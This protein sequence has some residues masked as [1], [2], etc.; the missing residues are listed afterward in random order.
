MFKCKYHIKRATIRN[1][2]GFIWKRQPGKV[3]ILSSEE[4]LREL[5]LLNLQKRDLINSSHAEERVDLFRVALEFKSKQSG[6]QFSRGRSWLSV[7]KDSFEYW[8]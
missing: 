3:E 1:K 7:R 2:L 4:K 6:G 8:N 5:G